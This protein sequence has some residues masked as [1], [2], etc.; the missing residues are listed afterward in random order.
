MF[1]WGDDA[2]G[3]RLG[4]AERSCPGNASSASQSSADRRRPRNS[5]PP[6]SAK[7]SHVRMSVAWTIVP[8]RQVLVPPTA[9][10]AIAYNSRT[11]I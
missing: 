6:R 1:A 9:K 3:A 5:D 8:P 11:R 2:T 10:N 7:G 4:L